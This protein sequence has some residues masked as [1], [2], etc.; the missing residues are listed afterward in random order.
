MRATCPANTTPS[1]DSGTNTKN[2]VSA[3]RMPADSARRPLRRR[4][5][6]LLQR[7]EDE[8]QHRRP[9]DDAAQRLE[10]AIQR[11]AEDRGGDELEGAAIEERVH[12]A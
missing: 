1:T 8:G 6:P 11:V 3:V 10:D 2:G 5:E 12:P 4:V 9:A 7:V